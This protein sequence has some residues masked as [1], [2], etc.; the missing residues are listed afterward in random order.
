MIFSGGVCPIHESGSLSFP[1]FDSSSDEDEY[2]STAGNCPPDPDLID[3]VLAG[4]RLLEPAVQEEA[5]TSLL[6]DETLSDL[7]PRA[8]QEVAA[9]KRTEAE[10]GT[11]TDPLQR[12]AQERRPPKRLRPRPA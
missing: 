8:A 12:P 2:A 7:L 3:D 10:T 1:S 4:Q 11:I 5:G 6:A 9:S